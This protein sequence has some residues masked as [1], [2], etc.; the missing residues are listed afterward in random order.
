M[1]ST[2]NSSSTPAGDSFELAHINSGSNVGGVNVS[3]GGFGSDWYGRINANG[4][5]HASYT[6]RCPAD[7]DAAIL[8][9]QSDPASF[10]KAHGKR[11][12]RCCFCAREFDR[13]VS[14]EH[15]YGPDCADKYGL[16]F[17]H[18]RYGKG[19][20]LPHEPVSP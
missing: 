6:D 19:E 3:S 11:T 14:A 20:Q 10:A 5:A 17:D 4:A 1:P 9:F 12:S 18:A 8:A 7:V 2:P 15:G 16:P 13:L